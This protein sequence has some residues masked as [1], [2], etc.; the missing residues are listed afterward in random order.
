MAC[1]E[2]CEASIPETARFCP[3]CGRLS[4]DSK[5][6][7]IGASAAH[8]LRQLS[9]ALIA[10]FAYYL[11]AIFIVNVWLPSNGHAATAYFSLL[12]LMGSVYVVLHRLFGRDKICGWLLLSSTT[13]LLS[14]STWFLL[15]YFGILLIYSSEWAPLFVQL[16]NLLALAVIDA[17]CIAIY[18]QYARFR[19]H[20]RDQTK[21]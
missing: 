5:D 4:G 12:S 19:H 6:G 16:A 13:V 20:R 2:K 17:I 18:V 10:C 9:Y 1:C 8:A 11:V 7:R 3:K 21:N 14:F 15:L